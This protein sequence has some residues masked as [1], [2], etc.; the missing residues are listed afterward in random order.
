MYDFFKIYVKYTL[1]L[2]AKHQS[3]D[4]YVGDVGHHRD[5]QIWRIDLVPRLDR[6]AVRFIFDGP[7]L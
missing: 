4:K 6:L 5:I 1:F 7:I 2:G 3:C